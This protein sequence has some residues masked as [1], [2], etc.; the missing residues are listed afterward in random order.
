MAVLDEL[1]DAYDEYSDTPDVMVVSYE[2]WEVMAE[3]NSFENL[4]KE[5]SNDYPYANEHRG[6]LGMYVI[7]SSAVSNHGKVGLL[8]SREAFKDLFDASKDF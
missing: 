6:F 4:N 7:R 8:L 5:Q 1:D 2:Q 3:N